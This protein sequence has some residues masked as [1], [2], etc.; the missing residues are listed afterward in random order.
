MPRPASDSRTCPTDCPFLEH[1]LVSRHDGHALRRHPPPRHAQRPPDGRRAEAAPRQA[2]DVPRRHHPD[3]RRGRRADQPV[4]PGLRGARR[5]PGHA[6]RAARA[7]PPG[8]AVHPR[9]RADPGLPAYVAA[10]ARLARRPRLRPQRRRDHHA[11]HRPRADVR[12]ARARP[13]REGARPQPGADDRAGARGARARRARTWP[14]PPR[15]FAPQPL[16]AVL[17]PPDHIVSITYTGGTTGQA[18]GRHRHRPGDVHDDPGP[19]RRVGVAGVAALPDVYAALARRRSLLRADRDQGRVALRAAALRPGRGAAHDRGA[20]DHRHHAGAVDALRADGPP[21][22]AH[23][24]PVVA[25]DR[26][27]R[28]VR[29]QP[30]AA[31]RRRSSGS[32][33]SSPSTTGSPRRRW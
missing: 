15:T 1:V 28:R 4:H 5:R 29:D 13:A 3:R 18:Q 32:G 33:R 26:L 31:G 25:G 10:P 21:R 19:A 7:E 27:L 22:L 9:C 23:A 17:L 12:R 2:G 24:R 6:R 30:G 14:R 16:E 20:E 11:D 8:G